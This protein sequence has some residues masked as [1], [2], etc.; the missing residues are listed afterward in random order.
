MITDTQHHPLVG[1]TDLLQ[2]FVPNDTKLGII[3]NTAIAQE[4]KGVVRPPRQ[5]VALD[6]SRSEFRRR[7]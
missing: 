1:L 4:M 5:V 3:V 7:L 2:A 6:L